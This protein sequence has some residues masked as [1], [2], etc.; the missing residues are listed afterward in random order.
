MAE[1]EDRREPEG[2]PWKFGRK[3]SDYFF[4]GPERCMVQDM[5]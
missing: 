2:P 5:R 4:T 3:W 1:A